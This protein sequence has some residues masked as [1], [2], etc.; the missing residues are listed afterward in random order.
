MATNGTVLIV[1]AINEYL[2][3]QQKSP[4]TVATMRSALN[5]L[6]PITGDDLELG[7]LETN[8]LIDYH[9]S[10]R[11]DGLKFKSVK[12]YTGMATRFFKYLAL[13]KMV[14]FTTDDLELAKE[15]MAS[16]NGR[17]PK[18]LPKL[19]DEEAVQAIIKLA[20]RDT[21]DPGTDRQT[22]AAMRN[23][24]MLHTLRSTG[25]RV[26]EMLDLKI[27]DITWDGGG[28]GYARVIGKGE[29][30]RIVFFDNDATQWV[31]GWIHEHPDGG[32]NVPVFVRLDRQIDDYQMALTS[33]SVRFIM[34]EL[35][36][37]AGVKRIT[38]HMMRHRFGTALYI[39]AG[40][41]A[42]ADLMGHASTDTTREYARLAKV[43]MKAVHAKADL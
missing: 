1:D 4:H 22:W 17:E 11:E 8:D 32:N 35:C 15:I 39:A 12:T 42:A 14:T 43:Q 5:R 33:E 37:R 13:R 26:Q 36:K 18:T 29:K 24:A 3:S 34:R 31:S 2:D 27:G 28:T 25:V 30:E 6:I 9:H 21:A 40:L 41:G 19:P 20:E 23:A 38:P 10:L 7:D 16:R